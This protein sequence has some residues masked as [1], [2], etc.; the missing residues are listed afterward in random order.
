MIRS[1]LLSLTL[2]MSAFA[3]TAVDKSSEP[4][5]TPMMRTVDPALVKAGEPVTIKGEHLSKDFI[6]AV[7]VTDGK[8]DRQV[9]LETQ[10]DDTVTFKVPSELKPGMYKVVVLLNVVEPTLVEE[11]VRINVTE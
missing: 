10:T 3:G 9:T 4:K 8:K 2:A 7:Y 5:P 11:P 1:L 6:S